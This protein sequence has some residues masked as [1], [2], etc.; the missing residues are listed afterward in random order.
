[1]NNE[2]L[3]VQKADMALADLATSGLLNPEQAN[4][5]VRVAIESTPLMSRVRSVVMKSPVKHID[6][7]GFGSRVLR[8]AVSSTALADSDR[9]KPDQSQVILTTKEVMAEIHLP[10]DVLE[11]NIEGGNVGVPLQTG[12]GGLHDTLVTLLAQRAGL[13]LEEWGINGDTSS[14]DGYLAQAD[15]WLKLMNQNIVNN[16]AAGFSKDSVKAALRA[17]PPKYLQNRANMLHFVSVNN[18]TE[19]RDQH[20]TRQTPMGDAN[21]QGNLPLYV[22]GSQVTGVPNMPEAS[23]L[24]TQ[25]NNLIFG[26]QRQIQLEYDKDIRARVFIVVL[27]CRVA[28]AIEEANAGVRYSNL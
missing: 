12:A 28:F 18:E 11:D 26:I 14:A 4:T 16:G 22:F 6:K 10:Y 13:D 2:Q 1:M 8:P 5:F 23:G 24:F 17:T 19:L 7:I 20:G 27:T 15:G 9:V 3:L 21:I 25:P